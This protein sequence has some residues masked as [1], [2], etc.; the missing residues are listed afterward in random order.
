MKK[1]IALFILGIFAFGCSDLEE[2]PVGIIRPANFFNNTDDLQAAV[3]GAYANIAHNN[4]WGREFTISLMLRDDMADIGDRT[5]QAARIDVNDFNMNDTN[6][7]VANFWPQSYIIIA[8]ANQAIEG[9][10]KTPGDPAKV[11]AIVAQA[12]FARAFTYYHLVR[13]FGDIPYIDFAVNDVS[14]VNSLSR[15][16]EADVYP[17]IIAD[18]EFAKQ[19]LE[20]KPKVKAIPGKGTA[21]GYLASVYLTLGQYQKAYDEAKFVITNEAKFGLGLDADFQDLFNATKTAALKE[22]LFTV[23]FNNLNSGNYGIDYTAF[24]TG[25][26]TDETYSYGQGFSVAVPSQKV[27]DTWDQRDYRR[28]VS[29]DT[30]LR[31]KVNGVLTV[32]PSSNNVKAP[33]PHIAKYYRF[34]GKAGANG[35][36]SQHNY[37]TMR[38]A[39]VLLTAAEALNEITPGTPEADGYVNRVRARAR[40]KAGKLVSFPANVTPGM[41]Q[42]DFKKMVI[43]ERRLEFAFE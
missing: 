21:A 42:S 20:D 7:L 1:Y 19:Y 35:R 10:K 18:L 15:T 29:F 38:Y 25:S 36:T 9:A 5:T 32:F 12:Y 23:D 24:F 39:E 27:F 31:K 13:I 43:E 8:A 16:K 33:R 34:P 26:L 41:S 28:A 4:Y 14:Q 2:H 40:N 6:S 3:N 37:I 11:N 17:K 22:P 30:V